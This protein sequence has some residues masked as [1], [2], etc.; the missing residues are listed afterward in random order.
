MAI[1]EEEL[2]PAPEAVPTEVSEPNEEQEP[3]PESIPATEETAGQTDQQEPAPTPKPK[4]TKEEKR[5]RLREVYTQNLK[6]LTEAN[7]P[8]FQQ[9]QAIAEKLEEVNIVAMSKMEELWGLEVIE[10][11]AD[12][13]ISLFYRARAKGPKS[14]TPSEKG[15]DVATREGKPR[16]IGGIFFHLMIEYTR[17]QGYSRTKLDLPWYPFEVPEFVMTFEPRKPKPEKAPP[18]RS[19][20][21]KRK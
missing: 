17:S 4:L 20:K 10:Q 8:T 13:A 14:Y 12:E 18:T 7:T 11:K 6:S 21:K 2:T 15:T 9:L 16:S 3:L 5:I 1:D 19:E